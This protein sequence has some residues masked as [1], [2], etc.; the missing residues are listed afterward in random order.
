M[1]KSVGLI[2]LHSWWNYGSMLQAYAENRKLNQIG[3]DC[4]LIDFTPAK[5]YNIRSYRLYNEELNFGDKR[6]KYIED[7][8]ARKAKFKAFEK[9]YKSSKGTWGCDEDINLNP[10]KYDAYITGGDQLWNI[11][12]RLESSAYFLHF[13][14]STEKYAFSTSVGRCEINQLRKY[15]EDINAYK[16]IFMRE[17][18]GKKKIQQLI[19]NPEK[20]DVM[21]DPTM[22]LEVNEWDSIISSQRIIPGEYIACYATLD[23]ELSD[24]MP[25]LKCIHEKTKKRIV[26]FGMI[27]PVD[28]EWID[29]Y[30]ACGPLEMLNLIKYADMVLTHSFHGTVFSILFN[31]DFFTYNDSGLNPR[32]EELLEAFGLRERIVYTEDDI[33][34]KIGKTIEYDSINAKLKRL[35]KDTEIQIRECLG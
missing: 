28:Q 23:S 7:M 30:V 32:K 5:I 11:N 33:L 22:Q 8:G 12:M 25:I 9:L 29:N 18:D 24:M 34:K 13:A 26:L 3:Y 4:E 14:D 10:P 27:I 31:K 17:E 2:T 1:K 19:A 21:L 20:V 35:R 6:N 15:A 16:K